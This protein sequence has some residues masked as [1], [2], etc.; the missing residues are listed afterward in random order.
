MK[1][2]DARL[3]QNVKVGHNDDQFKIVSL[4]LRTNSATLEDNS[5]QC[6]NVEIAKLR[7]VPKTYEQRIESTEPEIAGYYDVG[8]LG[9]ILLV[10]ASG[11]TVYGRHTALGDIKVQMNQQRNRLTVTPLST[12]EN[13]F[14]ENEI[15][16][17][18]LN[19]CWDWYLIKQN[20]EI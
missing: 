15:F 19:N 8:M 18:M 9:T 6:Y 13:K 4:D 1:I 3:E 2:T 5:G 7:E 20:E 11:E 17:H 16:H 10:L 14:P 12:N